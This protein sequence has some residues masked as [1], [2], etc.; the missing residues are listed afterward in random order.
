MSEEKKVEAVHKITLSTG[1]VVMMR[2]MRIRYQ[3]LAIKAVGSQAKDNQALLGTLAQQELLKILIANVNGK[4]MTHRELE[5]LD[6]LFSY[7]E[8]IQLMKVLDKISGG[9]DVGEF[10]TEIVMSGDR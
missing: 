1:K 8:L 10:Q 9:D 2:E 4:E 6:E 5:K 3:N 7:P